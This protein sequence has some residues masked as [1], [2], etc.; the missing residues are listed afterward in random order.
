MMKMGTFFHHIREAAAERG[1]TLEQTLEYVREL[2]Y[3]AAEVDA[4]DHE[5]AELLGA[6]GIAVSSI[7]R[8]YSWHDK[9]DE[10]AMDEALRCC[11]KLGYVTIPEFMIYSGLK[12]DS[13]KCY[14][15]S[16]CEGEN[17]RLWKV[18]ESRRWLYFPKRNA[19][20]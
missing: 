5:G 10:K 4:D 16:L 1:E 17:P 3:E 6:H 9:I 15:D 19:S 11:M 12:R 13:A 7:Y 8:N 20:K 2:G 18:R 14:L